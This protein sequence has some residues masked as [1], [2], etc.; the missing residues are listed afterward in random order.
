MDYRTYLRYNPTQE[1]FFGEYGG[2]ELPD[3]L[4]AAFAHRDPLAI[5][6]R[7]VQE[8]GWLTAEAVAAVQAECVDEVQHCMAQAQKEPT[9][10]PAETDW[11]AVSWKPSRY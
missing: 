8:Q 10:V 4:K 1:G 5:A 11:S 2:A 7:Q 3:E 6:R 9:P